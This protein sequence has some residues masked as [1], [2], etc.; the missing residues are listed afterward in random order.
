ME[1]GPVYTNLTVL[2]EAPG[3]DCR[4][5]TETPA[6]EAKRPAGRPRKGG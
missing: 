2:A 5:F 3:V 1:W 4:A 6:D